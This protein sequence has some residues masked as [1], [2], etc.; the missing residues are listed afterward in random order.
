MIFDYLNKEYQLD[1]DY[2]ILE[3]SDKIGGR[4]LTHHFS[5]ERHDY[6]D[7]GAM[8]FPNNGIMKR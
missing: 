6:Y 5:E 3:A 7:V 4:L 1:V 8:R 2:Q